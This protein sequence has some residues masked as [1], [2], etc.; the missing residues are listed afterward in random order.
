MNGKGN[1]AMS[2]IHQMIKAN[3]RPD[4]KCFQLA[5]SACSYESNVFAA[6]QLYKL[7]KDQFAA[8]QKIDVIMVDVYSRANHLDKAEEMVHNIRNAKQKLTAWTILS[9]GCKK[10][11]EHDR[12]KRIFKDNPELLGNN[13]MLHLGKNIATAAGDMEDRAIYAAK[14]D[15]HQLRKIPGR[16]AVVIGDKLCTFQVNDFSVAQQ[17]TDLIDSLLGVFSSEYGYTP[18]ISCVIKE[19]DTYEQKVQSLTRHSEKLAVA[20][21]L[22]EP[23]YHDIEVSKNLRICLDCHTF[24]KHLSRHYKRTFIIWDKSFQHTFTDGKCS[25]ND[26]Y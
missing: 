23:G 22:L 13:S 15:E 24:V 18:D 9:S 5:L 11:G 17:A 19:Y 20:M 12:L 21:A 3:I 1:I 10:Y 6:E 7:A 26:F 25:C 2:L 4:L 8:E 14:L 16:S